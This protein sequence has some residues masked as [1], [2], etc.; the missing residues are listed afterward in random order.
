MSLHK[1]AT[2]HIPYLGKGDTIGILSTARKIKEEEL[3]PAIE[4]AESW[5]LAIVLGKTIGASDN[6]YAGTDTL[7][8]KDFQEMLDNPNIKALWCAKGGYGTVRI[9]DGLDFSNFQKN[10]KWIIG[11]SDVTVLHN[12]INT[13]GFATIHGGMAQFI[14]KASQAARA[15]LREAL[16]GNV[17]AIKNVPMTKWNRLGNAQGTL[18]GGNLSVLCSVLGSPSQ[19]SFKNAILFIEDI[20]EMHYHIDRMMQLL[21]RSGHLAQL[22]GLVVGGMTA[23]RDNTI[24]FGKTANQIIS[25]AVSEYRYP[26]CFDFPAGHIVDNRALVLGTT[27]CLAVQK[28]G[29]ALR[30]FTS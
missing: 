13:L 17:T 21:K 6:Q 7:R 20:D 5:G 28:E 24:P 22:K 30:Y 8:T 27:V 3:T 10:P 15:T 29:V 23:M 18:V 14:E 9:V 11:Y 4:L 25:E 16:F 12:H 26:V 1:L 19:L 2:M